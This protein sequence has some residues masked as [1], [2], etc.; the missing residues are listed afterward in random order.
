MLC[1]E[2]GHAADGSHVIVAHLDGDLAAGKLAAQLG[3]ELAGQHSTAVLADVGAQGSFDGQAAVGA[4]Q[5][6]ALFIRLDQHT[7]QNL[8]GRTRCQRTGDGIQALQELLYVHGKLHAKT[9]NLLDASHSGLFSPY[10]SAPKA[11]IAV[12]EYI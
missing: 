12:V 4:G 3:E 8:L 1:H 5:G 7:L 6:D 10:A 9:S 2:E 11:R